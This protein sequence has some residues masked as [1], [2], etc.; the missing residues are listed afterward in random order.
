MGLFIC[1]VHI[2]SFLKMY[3]FVVLFQ[4]VYLLF[5]FKRAKTV[6]RSTGAER[7]IFWCLECVLMC[8]VSAVVMYYWYLGTCLQ[9]MYSVN[10]TLLSSSQGQKSQ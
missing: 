5:Y 4:V 6:C 3:M 1:R 10:V 2:L 8:N 9:G 7:V